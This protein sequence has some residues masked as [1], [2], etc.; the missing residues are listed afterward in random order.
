[1]IEPLARARQLVTAQMQKVQLRMLP[2]LLVGPGSLY[3]VQDVLRDQDIRCVMIVTTEGFVKRGVVPSF[4]QDL[5]SHGIT[6]A[7]FSEVT[8]DP[9]VECVEKAA[10]FYRS[11]GCEGIVAIGGGS[12]MD[13]AKIAGALAVKPNKR[14]LDLVGTMKVRTS[15]PYLVA[16][17]TT[18]GTGSEVTAAAVLTDPERQRKYA[19]SDIALIPDVAVLDPNLLLGL[20]PEM[21]AYTGMDALTHAVEAYTNRYGS[22]EARVYARRAV[23]I[24]FKD[25]KASYDDGRDASL[26][27]NMLIASYYAGVAFTNNMV[28]YVHALAHGIGG[29]YHV[30]HGLANAV[31]LPVVLEEHTRDDSRDPRRGHPRV[32]GGGRGRGQSRLPCS[33]CVE[34]SRFRAGAA[35]RARRGSAGGSDCRRAPVRRHRACDRRRGGR[36]ARTF[37]S[38]GEGGRS[39]CRCRRIGR[40]DDRQGEETPVVL[41]GSASCQAGTFTP[42]TWNG[43]S[44]SGLLTSWASRTSTRSSSATTFPTSTWALWCLTRRTA[45]ITASPISLGLP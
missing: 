18:A 8:P 28:G 24:V 1:M 45:S 30:Q 16:V 23:E 7:V 44:R 38:Q 43:C 20:S 21:T 13:C 17:P 26:R 35:A 12:V 22:R 42:P 31:L 3:D 19:V 29:R 37:Q 5:L 4:T 36:G 10:A 41:V 40:H 33:R 9:D 25:L 14:A 2:E 11:R 39:G 34:P 15:L 6:S 27:E 32:G